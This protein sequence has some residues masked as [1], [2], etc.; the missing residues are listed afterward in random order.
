MRQPASL[1]RIVGIA[2]VL[3]I[4]VA[5]AG[6]SLLPGE[7]RPPGGQARTEQRSAEPK[8]AATPEGS[9]GPPTPSPVGQPPGA[10]ATPEFARQVRANE[11]GLVPVLMYHRVLAK[12]IASLDRTPTQLRDELEKLAKK[13]YVPITAREFVTGDIR[14]P[15]GKFPVV[16][17]F[18][19]GHRSHFG[20]DASGAPR[21]DSAVG[22][23]EDVARRYPGFRPTA[24]FWIN[25][26]PF[27]LRDHD[28]QAAAVR[29]LVEHGYEVANHTWSHPD[30]RRLKRKKVQEQIVRIERLLG[31]LGAPPSETMALPYGSL[32]RGKKP[33]RTGSWDGTRYDF[34][35][36]FLAGA[37]PSLSPYAKK[38]D[39]GAIQRI[40]SN[41]KKGECRK[42]CSQYWL[43][44]LDKHPGE[45][46]VSDGD[47]E[48][49]SMP[50]NLR[51]N[52]VAKRG[53][54][55]IVY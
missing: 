6:L 38:F 50:E 26:E 21:P 22:V 24:T 7:P 44:W 45:R 40:Q 3:V 16:L 4:V 8:A 10:V 17:T 2:N 19:D 18:D 43:E 36:V 49:I 28:A 47:P 14:V 46:F 34:A 41:G 31:K 27:G 29:W 51:G 9:P 53:R 37:E 39:R 15:A 32:P 12:R 48:R 55:V 13:G 11:A 35:G 1:T 23:I 42:W 25:R 30:L 5:V 52:I 20:L 33:A 54:E